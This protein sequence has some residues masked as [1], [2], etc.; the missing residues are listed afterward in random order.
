[1]LC[2]GLG[3]HRNLPG[4][5]GHDLVWYQDCHGET[6][7]VRGVQLYLCQFGA[8]LQE[9]LILGFMGQSI[10]RLILVLGKQ[11]PSAVGRTKALGTGLWETAV[12]CE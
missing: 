5:D 10:T 2:S 11:D 1:M 9:S 4:G 3:S 6:S 12:G 8:T 7:S